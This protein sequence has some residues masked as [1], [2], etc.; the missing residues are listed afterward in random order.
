MTGLIRSNAKWMMNDIMHYQIVLPKSLHCLC[1]FE[2]TI[3][4]IYVVIQVWTH[5]IYEFTLCMSTLAVN[6]EQA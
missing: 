6:S 1:M 3:R 4:T 5:L 2:H